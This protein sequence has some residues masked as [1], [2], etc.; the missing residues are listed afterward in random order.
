MILEFFSD[1]D[2]V[3]N[4]RFPHSKHASNEVLFDVFYEYR[5]SDEIL[6]LIRQLKIIINDQYGSDELIGFEFGDFID[7]EIDNKFIYLIPDLDFIKS[8][9]Y[10]IKIKSFFEAL[11]QWGKFITESKPNQKMEVNIDCERIKIIPSYPN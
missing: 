5:S 10:K 9:K 8:D 1:S 3:C 11:Y 7:G 4:V 6:D 2:S